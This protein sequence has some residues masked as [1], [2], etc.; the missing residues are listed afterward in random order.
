MD[1]RWCMSERGCGCQ[2]KVKGKGEGVC[3]MTTRGGLE[4]LEGEK[5][6]AGC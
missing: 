5:G 3:R 2:S 1:R 6:G 4:R